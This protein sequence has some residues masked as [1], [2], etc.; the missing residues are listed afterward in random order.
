MN[1]NKQILKTIVDNMSTYL[2]L[3]PSY[4]LSLANYPPKAPPKPLTQNAGVIFCYYDF[5]LL[6]FFVVSISHSL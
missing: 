5:S 6:R 2:P 1:K 3:D 4:E